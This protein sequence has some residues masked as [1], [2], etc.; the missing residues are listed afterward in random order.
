MCRTRCSTVDADSCSGKTPGPLTAARCAPVA[1]GRSA[2]APARPGSPARTPGLTFNA[3]RDGRHE[4]GP[5]GA[6]PIARHDGGRG[7][8]PSDD[9]KQQPGP[10]HGPPARGTRLGR[11]LR[12]YQMP[13]WW[14]PPSSWR[15]CALRAR[16]WPV[17]SRPPSA[18]TDALSAI[19]LLVEHGPEEPRTAF[20]ARLRASGL[21]EP[22]DP[23][24]AD[25]PAPAW[26]RPDLYGAAFAATVLP[27]LGGSERRVGE[28]ALS[29]LP[30]ACE[31]LPGPHR[32]GGDGAVI[33]PIV[34]WR[35]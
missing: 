30:W 35:A 7:V 8:H 22:Y 28:A 4:R 6:A 13:V 33:T 10:G 12:L 1:H 17:T 14:A 15:V 5:A 32:S 34:R 23:L 9:R 11:R 29:T 18:A 3:W 21:R 19:A 31:T 20:L 2:P 25:C 26:R 24:G 27:H 16:C